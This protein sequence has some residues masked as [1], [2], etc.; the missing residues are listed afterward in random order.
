M[1][2]T[3]QIIRLEFDECKN[4]DD[5]ELE[6]WMDEKGHKIKWISQKELTNFIER[7]FV[8]QDKRVD[9]KFQNY[10]DSI[11]DYFNCQ[12]DLKCFNKPKVTQCDLSQNNNKEV[13]HSSH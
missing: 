7:I 1:L 12:F 6:N 3:E 9:K 4:M 11:V 5:K 13:R 10:L 2:S 8:Y